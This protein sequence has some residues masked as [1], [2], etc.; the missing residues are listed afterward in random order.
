MVELTS[1]SDLLSSALYG[2]VPILSEKKQIHCEI[3][4]LMSMVE[5][6]LI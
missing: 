4:S 1:I 2:A 6:V 3:N 5:K